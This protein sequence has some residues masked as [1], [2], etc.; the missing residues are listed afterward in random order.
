MCSRSEEKHELM[1]P[2]S[3]VSDFRREREKVRQEQEIPGKF[4]PQFT[5]IVVY[6]WDVSSSSSLSS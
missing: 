6:C 5:R 2:I 3:K 4:V 1:S